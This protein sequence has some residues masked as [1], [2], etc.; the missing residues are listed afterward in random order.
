MLLPGRTSLSAAV[1]G[2]HKGEPPPGTPEA[3]FLAPYCALG[4]LCKSRARR[5]TVAALRTKK[6]KIR[7]EKVLERNYFPLYLQGMVFWSRSVLRLSWESVHLAQFSS[8]R[9]PGS[10]AGEGALPTALP[11]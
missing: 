1:E 7:K 5:R 11:E 9:P 10:P 2:G 8:R 4:W 6:C 3:P